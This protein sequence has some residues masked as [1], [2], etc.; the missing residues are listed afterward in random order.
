MDLPKILWLKRHMSPALFARAHFFDLPDY[1]TFRAT[2]TR[3][4]SACSLTC[5]CSFIP[6]VGW[7]EP[8]FRTI[9][10]E[11]IVDRGYG[12]IGAETR[13]QVLTA[14]LPVGQG[15]SLDAAAELGLVVGTPV[16]SALIDA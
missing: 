15:L 9:G 11:D 5:K 2:G 13:E 4:R 8:F 10:L 6:H 7:Q 1:L 12:Q 16:G 14:G 3:T